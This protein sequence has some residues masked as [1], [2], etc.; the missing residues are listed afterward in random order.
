[1]FN[2]EKLLGGLIR[3]GVRGRGLGRMVSGG[4][5]LGLVGV[6]M[7]AVEHYMGRPQAESRNRPP[8]PPPLPGSAPPPPPPSSRVSVPPRPPAGSAGP[9]AEPASGNAAVLLIRAMI[10]AANA[11]GV[12]DTQERTRILE[13]LKS[14]ELSQQEHEFILHELLAPKD[15]QDIVSEVNTDD[16]ARQV[17]AASLLA[18]EVDTEEEKGYLQRLAANLGLDSAAINAIHRQVQVPRV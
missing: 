9:V 5:A 14:L 1:M 4:A 13:K 8:G 15:M 16:L 7:E 6:A 18:I 3:S 10:A 12:I 2:P 17:Y 11:D